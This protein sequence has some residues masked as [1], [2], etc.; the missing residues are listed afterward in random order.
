MQW[1]LWTTWWPDWTVT[2][3][4]YQY[5]SDKNKQILEDFIGDFDTGLEGFNQMK[6]WA[7][8]K[9]LA[10]K[11]VMEPPAAK[12]DANG[13]LITD[14]NKLEKLY[15]EHTKLHWLQT[16]YL[17]ILVDL[18]LK[19]YLFS[20]RLWLAKQKMSSDWTLNNL[21][22]VLKSLKNDKARDAHGHIYELYKFA[23][24]DLKF[25]MLRMFNMMKRKQIYPSIFQH[26]NI[27]SFYK[28][29]G[30]RSDL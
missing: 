19:E 21:E 27:S 26:S 16:K 10:P 1:W 30:D 11:S 20:L 22:N 4:V 23:G 2:E 15:L 13:T 6:T 14:I 8:K 7:L 9:R 24:Y 12:K 18:S 17:K 25:S 5:C 29:K 3:Q 28:K